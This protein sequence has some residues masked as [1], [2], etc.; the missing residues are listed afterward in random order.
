M[1]WPPAFPK[2]YVDA[3]A[4]RALAFQ[5]T[6]FFRILRVGDAL[7]PLEE[8][9]STKSTLFKPF[10]EPAVLDR[11]T[12]SIEELAAEVV[13]AHGPELSPSC[14]R[15]P[16]HLQMAALAI[17]AQ[18]ALLHE[19]RHGDREY[20]AVTPFKVRS[21]VANALGVVAAP[22]GTRPVAVPAMWVPNKLAMAF[23]GGLWLPERRRPIVE[24][25][26]KN[27]VADLGEAFTLEP[28]DPE[29]SCRMR[30]CFYHDL[31]KAEDELIL[32]P[33]FTAMHGATWSGVPGFEFVAHDDPDDA[34]GATTA[35][36]AAAQSTG[37]CD[38][39]FRLGQ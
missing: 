22:D 11:V 9:S 30:R 37:A 4:A 26:M 5:R 32:A 12:R 16:A 20:L 17:G 38:F 8:S 3:A 15:G 7:V 19:A 24:R 39:L 10:V 6:T 36:R 31:L 29:P 13:A 14:K 27:F 35:A 23:T 2:G 28:L 25:M 18:R 1:P 21:V 34:S 33:V